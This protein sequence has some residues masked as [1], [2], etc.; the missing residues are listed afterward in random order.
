MMPS[1]NAYYKE[2]SLDPCPLMVPDLMHNVELGLKKQTL[3]HILRIFHAVGGGTV[4]EFDAR[5]VPRTVTLS[6]FRLPPNQ[7]SGCPD[8][9]PNIRAL[10]DDNQTTEMCWNI[11]KN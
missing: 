5:S 7:N 9:Q 10:G 3:L 1:Q 11:S 6:G 8:D 2:L 4:Q